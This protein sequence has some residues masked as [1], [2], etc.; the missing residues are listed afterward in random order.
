MCLIDA[1]N[2]N[3]Y[4]STHLQL[5]V[6]EELESDRYL[7]TIE[8]R[9]NPSSDHNHEVTLK[10]QEKEVEHSTG[11]LYQSGKRKRQVCILIR[12]FVA[13][14]MLFLWAENCHVVLESF[15]GLGVCF[16]ESVEVRFVALLDRYQLHKCFFYLQ[17]L[18]PGIFIPSKLSFLC[19][20]ASKFLL[21]RHFSWTLTLK[22][23]P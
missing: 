2:T 17:I 19:S 13:V 23:E 8:E 16:V 11:P 9:L 18:L 6:G 3:A 14:H 1:Y 12:C 5:A 22:N 7:I 4:T 20:S 10:A 15:C 21:R